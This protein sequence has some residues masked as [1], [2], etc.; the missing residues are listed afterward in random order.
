MTA[1]AVEPGKKPVFLEDSTRSAHSTAAAPITMQLSQTNPRET[2]Q[3]IASTILS[4][5]R[6]QKN[7]VRHLLAALAAGGHVLLEDYPG[8]GKTTL[9]KAL[10]RAIDSD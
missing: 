6:G 4:V 9:A 2:Y 8:T 7:S 10:A 5:M 3:K 1:S